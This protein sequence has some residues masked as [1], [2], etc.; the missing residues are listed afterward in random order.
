MNRLGKPQ[1]IAILA[2]FLFLL[3]AAMAIEQSYAAA[4]WLK[5]F[6]AGLRLARST[7]KPLFAVIR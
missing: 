2:S 3:P 5:D 1:T 4:G 7:G 6:S